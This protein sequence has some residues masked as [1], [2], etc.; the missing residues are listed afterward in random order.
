M[1]TTIDYELTISDDELEASITIPRGSDDVPPLTEFLAHLTEDEGLVGIDEKALQ[2]ALDEAADGGRV[3]PVVIARGK[4]PVD[5]KDAHLDWKGEFFE[6]VPIMR[7]DGSVDHFHRNKT[8]V[9]P[10][11]IIA[12]WIAPGEGTP[13]Q[14]IRG[15][16]IDPVPGRAWMPK[17]HETV[18]W[19]D[20]THRELVA[21]VGGQVEFAKDRVSISQVYKTS[22]VDFGSSSIDFEGAVEVEGDVLEGFDVKA[23]GS[24]AIS[25]YVECS[26]VDSGGRLTV[27][28]GVIGQNKAVLRA[29]SD[30]EV[31]FL[32][33]L[34][35]ECGGQLVSHGELMRV[36]AVVG[37]DVTAEK[38]RIVGGEW[39]IGG[40]L[41]AG[42]LGSES[43]T[44][45]SIVVGIDNDLE[46]QQEEHTAARAAHQAEIAQREA[47]I[48]SLSAKR[49]RTEKEEIAFGKLKMY[50]KQLQA[51][52]RE[53]A[54]A[55]RLLRRRIKMHRRHGTV[56]IDG[57]IHPGVKIFCGGTPQPLEVTSFIKGPVRVGY[58]P[59]RQKPAITHGRNKKFESEW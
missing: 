23:A 14:N 33:E 28:K 19:V 41:Y 26:S 37:G 42:E 27:N 4:E 8:S 5:G 59:G 39:T 46:A 7:P 53:M 11:T 15:Q 2:D 20:E 50:L 6:A 43:E 36:E 3:G 58:L 54:E 44:P 56:W 35:L 22:A 24:V 49:K 34:D 12:Q 29:G 13:G 51:K 16:R 17:L 40:S 9:A 10:E 47:Q 1:T 18:S 57:G 31:G 25:G 55:D 52:D 48:E 45:T 38:N 30:V 21:L 32:R